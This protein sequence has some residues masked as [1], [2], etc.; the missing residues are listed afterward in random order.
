MADNRQYI[1]DLFR[2]GL[3][4]HVSA[5][6]P[7][8]WDQ[9]SGRLVKNGK[10]TLVYRVARYAAAGLLLLGM[11][12]GL[13]Y[14]LRHDSV[15]YSHPAAPAV[16]SLPA[17]AGRLPVKRDVSAAGIPDRQAREWPE[18]RETDAVKTRAGNTGSD[19]F[20]A[21]TADQ[22]ADQVLLR[23]FLTSM[24][25]G[26][27]KS[28]HQADKTIYTGETAGEANLPLLAATG[29]GRPGRWQASVMAAPN[30][31]YRSLTASNGDDVKQKF[32]YESGLVSFS[33][34][35][36]ISYRV[37]GR[38]SVLSGLDLVRIGNK[39]KGLMVFADQESWLTKRNSEAAF[40]PVS[41]TSVANSYGPV[42]NKTTTTDSHD[43][44]SPAF[45]NYDKGGHR[46][47]YMLGGDGYSEQV[48]G[49][50]FLQ[51]PLM[52]RYHVEGEKTNLIVGGGLGA[53]FLVGNQ[54]T[55]KHEGE[56]YDM[57][58]TRVN[59]FGLSGIFSV[60]L[61]RRLGSVKILFEPRFSHFISPINTEGNQ[62]ALPYAISFFGGIVFGIR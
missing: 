7:G 17:D 44:L 10:R 27:L 2:D 11:G 60:G 53:N 22:P 18:A 6:P 59:N 39:I 46:L 42:E 16:S 30:Y 28:S 33:G 37:N 52:L 58:R 32:Q 1:D 62:N 13:R 21:L 61:E 50:H 55:L 45:S 56:N 38:F 24:A 20:M 23:G 29:S 43:Y 4:D 31:S 47:N 49:F 26:S 51:A 57:G 34:S 40:V 54:I 5:P 8:A 15:T 48:H 41:G 14:I 35:L 12:G 36:N 3:K 9:I 25:P 19:L